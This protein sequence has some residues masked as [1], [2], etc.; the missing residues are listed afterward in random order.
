MTLLRMTLLVMTVLVTLIDVT[1]LLTDFTYH[2]FYLKRTLLVTVNI[3]VESWIAAEE[4][5]LSSLKSKVIISKVVL[6]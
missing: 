3:K 6:S 2:W 1:L 4:A 5:E